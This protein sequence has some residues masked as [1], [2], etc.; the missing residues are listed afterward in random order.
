[1]AIFA[2]IIDKFARKA[3]MS[4]MT[5]TL[6][7]RAMSAEDLE[8]VFEKSACNQYTN[9]L[10]FSSVVDIMGAVVCRAHPSVHAAFKAREREFPVSVAALYEKLK[11]T[12]TSTVE[13]LV[14]HCAGRL[15]ELVEHMGAGRMPRVPDWRV[16]FLDGNHYAATERR[17]EVTRG[18]IAGPLPGKALVFLDAQ[19]M[20]ATDVVMTKDGHAQERSLTSQ[21]LARVSRGELIVADRNFCTKS[22]LQ[23]IAER[24]AAFAIRHHANMPVDIKEPASKSKTKVREVAARVRGTSLQIRCVI[25]K[26]DT[27]TRDGDMDLRVLTNLPL[28]AATAKQIAKLYR[29]R[30]TIETAFQQ[31][32]RMLDGELAT[33]GYPGA[34]ALA[35][36]VALSCYNIYSTVQA[37][38]RT[39]FGEEVVQE[40][41]SSFYI[42]NEVRSTSG[43][44]DIATENE[45]W[46]A[47]RTDTVESVA[48]MLLECVGHVNIT[49]YRKAKR[50][51]K[52]P[53][54]KRTRYAKHGHVSTERL[55][56]GDGVE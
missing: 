22:I 27:P 38:L 15:N 45:D 24:D 11:N 20:L 5:R 33:L 49:T 9:K 21:L 28:S 12:E 4:V 41:V 26:R 10:L 51:K 43:G 3:P 31:M 19:S 34:A 23:G 32:S 42:A 50:G 44:L 35:F 48:E 52:N 14:G 13:A 25:I 30:W 6:L 39:R 16:R 56:R 8:T 18:S 55:L 7:V 37:A 53:V 46:S 17:L 54:P 36:G 1:M 2:G 40:Q 47:I 29:D